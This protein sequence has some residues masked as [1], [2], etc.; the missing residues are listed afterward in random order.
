MHAAAAEI[1]SAVLRHHDLPPAP[2]AVAGV[3][4]VGDVH[5][6]EARPRVEQVPAA[7]VVTPALLA[8][9]RRRAGVGRHVRVAVDGDA[10]LVAG[11]QAA[12]AGQLEHDRRQAV[13]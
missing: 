3:R 9:Q 11:E 2:R 1:H 5:G 12:A 10:L 7:L 13:E 6:A 8:A 4:R